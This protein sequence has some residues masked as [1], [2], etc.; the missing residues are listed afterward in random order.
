MPLD[1]TLPLQT[2]TFKVER[3]ALHASWTHWSPSCE[4]A[5]A[6][7]VLP[8]SGATGFRMAGQSVL[9]DSLTAMSLPTG[10]SKK[11]IHS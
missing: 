11:F 9:L 5:S 3:V 6:R 2:P 10:R 8:V 4:V 1:R 7:L